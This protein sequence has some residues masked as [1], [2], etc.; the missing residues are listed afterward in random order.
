MD[1]AQV[2]RLCHSALKFSDPEYS[3]IPKDTPPE[4]LPPEFIKVCWRH[5]KEENFVYIDSKESL[6][7]FLS[8]VYGLGIKK[9]AYWWQHKVQHSW[10]IPCLIKPQSKLPTDVW[11]INH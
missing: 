7:V 2:I 1:T 8:F 9:I 6:D 4:Q 5:G 11:A 10:I 3:G